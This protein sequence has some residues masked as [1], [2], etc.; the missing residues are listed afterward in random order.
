[1]DQDVLYFI[2]GRS[3]QSGR[4]VI[5]ST[6]ILIQQWTESG[7][8]G[9]LL[10][11]ACDVTSSQLA[12]VILGVVSAEA[13]NATVLT[14]TEKDRGVRGRDRQERDGRMEEKKEGKKER[15]E[16]RKT[17]KSLLNNNEQ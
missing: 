17:L 3:A 2:T 9:I 15:S 8:S 1:M 5:L 7:A 4:L 10:T 13:Q 11:Q 14:E 6:S 12:L 16:E